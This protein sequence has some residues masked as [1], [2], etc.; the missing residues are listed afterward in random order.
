MSGYFQVSIDTNFASTQ[1][2]HP[3]EMEHEVDILRGR[4]L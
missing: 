1:Q 2:K 3:E 4:R